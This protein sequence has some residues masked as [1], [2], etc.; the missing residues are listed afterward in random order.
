MKIKFV[1]TILYKAKL[2]G[3]PSSF[4]GVRIVGNNSKGL[5]L[6]CFPVYSRPNRRATMRYLDKFYTTSSLDKPLLLRKEQIVGQ[7][8]PKELAAI[9]VYEQRTPRAKHAPKVDYITEE[10]IKQ[11]QQE[12]AAAREK[13]LEDFYKGKHNRFERSWKKIYRGGGF[14]PR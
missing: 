6:I 1:S 13:D 2:P 8:S 11:Y 7:Y 10:Q 5:G 4:I 12:R 3:M 14:T 9:K